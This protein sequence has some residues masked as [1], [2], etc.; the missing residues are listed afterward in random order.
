MSTCPQAIW[1]ARPS[2][3]IDLVRP[4]IACLDAVYATACGRGTWAEI[5]PLLMILPPLRALRLH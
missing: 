2:S 4:V 3:E 5:E 1:N